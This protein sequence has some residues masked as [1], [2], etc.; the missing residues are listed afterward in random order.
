MAVLGQQGVV[1]LSR[2][3]PLPTALSADRLQKGSA[4][5]LDITEPAF[6]TGDEVLLVSL[7]GVPAGI[8]ITGFAPN[9]DGHAF[10]TDGI[11]DVGPALARRTQGGTFWGTNALRPF[12]ESADTVGLQQTM[13][14]FIYRDEVDDVLLYATELDAVNG[15]T[16]GLIPLRNVSTGPLLVLPASSRAGYTAAALA[17]LQAIGSQEVLNGEQEAEQL[18]PVPQ[19]LMDTAAD[20]EERGWKIQC[21][22]TNWVFETDATQ[23][24]QDAIGQAFGEYAKGMLRGAG[25]FNGEI[26]HSWIQGEQSGLG[27]LRLMLLT[28]QGSKARAQFQLVDQ[29][30]SN[31]PLV[32]ERVFYETDILLGKTSVDTKASDVILMSAQFVAT[33]RIKLAKQ[34]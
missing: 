21:D 3:W 23:L 28:G 5:T 8:G 17:L 27:M 31:L 14:A 7:R 29:R 9:P 2:E 12:W 26:D 20:A 22:L 18:A 15:G 32:P 6:Q 16:E 24:D 13:T 10:W 4:P 19:I 1:T 34:K 25:S 30:G 11:N 33:G